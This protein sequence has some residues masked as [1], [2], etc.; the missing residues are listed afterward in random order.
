[1]PL[2]IPLR[3]ILNFRSNRRDL[4]KWIL[5]FYFDRLRWT[6]WRR[7]FQAVNHRHR[8]E[9]WLYNPCNIYW[10]Q[11]KYWKASLPSILFS[12]QRLFSWRC[13][14]SSNIFRPRHRFYHLSGRRRQRWSSC[15]NFGSKLTGYC[16]RSDD[17]RCYFWW[18]LWCTWRSNSCI[19]RCCISA[20]RFGIP[21]RREP[22]F[23]TCDFCDF[24]CHSRDC[25]YYWGI[26]KFFD[27]I[28]CI[29]HQG[30]TS[31]VFC[32][33]FTSIFASWWWSANTCGMPPNFQDSSLTARWFASCC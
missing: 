30:S 8:L 22:T 24:L 3:C 16:R 7:I 32:R 33:W 19:Y 21:A 17:C 13:R 20:D 29:N 12:R 11:S 23:I 14:S 15:C 1:M 28:F 5:D 18:E 6:I 31:F 25:W 10:Q 2:N 4:S 26:A 27:H 9:R